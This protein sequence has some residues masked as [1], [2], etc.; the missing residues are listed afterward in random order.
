MS[1]GPHGICPEPSC[2]KHDYSYE[3]YSGP[4]VFHNGDGE[5]TCVARPCTEHHSFDYAQGWYLR[6]F[7]AVMRSREGDN[8]VHNCS[9]C[10]EEYTQWLWG[11]GQHRCAE[12][13][14]KA[15]TGK[16]PPGESRLA[17]FG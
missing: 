16:I 2:L 14:Y 12:C 7:E 17:V 6:F 10:G 5:P 11:W 8:P 15:A 1:R 9:Q 3:H 4:I 13:S